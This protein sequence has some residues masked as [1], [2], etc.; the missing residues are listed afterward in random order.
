MQK[1]LYIIEYE[2]AHWCGGQMHCVA[3]AYNAEQA[4]EVAE[5]H[6]CE[7]QLELFSAEYEEEPELEEDC[8]YVVNSVELLAGSEYEEFYNDPTQREAFYPCVN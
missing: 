1:Q 4:V 2:N 5:Q 8:P 6:M 7:E 3:W